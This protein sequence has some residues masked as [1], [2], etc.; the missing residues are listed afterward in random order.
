MVQDRFQ[1]WEQARFFQVLLQAGLSEYDELQGISESG[2]V[3]M[4]H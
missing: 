3:W 4:E 2:R 1:E